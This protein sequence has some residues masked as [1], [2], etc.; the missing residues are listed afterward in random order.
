MSRRGTRRLAAHGGE[1]PSSLTCSAGS[2]RSGSR[3]ADPLDQSAEK[4]GGRIVQR[5]TMNSSGRVSAEP[6]CI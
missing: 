2:W 1:S 6:R 4:T 5:E 3:H